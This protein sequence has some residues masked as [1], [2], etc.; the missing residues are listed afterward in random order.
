MN[1]GECPYTG[2]DGLLTFE[3]PE[4]TPA[5]VEAE[6]ETCKRPI[7]Y[8]LSRIDPM[9]WTRADFEAA[10]VIDIEARTITPRQAPAGAGH[11]GR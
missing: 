7:W 5:Y 6:C 8:R 10:F 9:A 4:R 1:I 3:V 2:C 11:D